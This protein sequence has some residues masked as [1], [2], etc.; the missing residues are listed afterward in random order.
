LDTLERPYPQ[1][2]EAERALLGGLLQRPEELVT[3]GTV[4]KAEDFYRPEHG[5]LLE[6]LHLM[7]GRGESIDLI[8]VSERIT[9]E[10]Q[11]ARYGGVA[12][13][14][15]LPDHAP[16]T[17]N[18]GHY[19]VVIK[20]KSMLRQLIRMSRALSTQA[21]GQPQDVNHLVTQAAQDF[22]S[23]GNT[24]SVRG[25]EQ[26][27][28]VVDREVKR[29]DDLESKGGATAGRTTGF[30]DLDERLSGLNPSDLVILAARPAMGKTA[31]ALNIA[32]NTALLE[33]V[34]VGLF[35]LEMPRGQL[36]TRMLCCYGLVDGGR[37]RNGKL[38]TD[39]WER[40][41]DAAEV[42]SKTP[43]FIDDTSGLSIGDVAARSRQLK[44]KNPDL[45]LIV[46][47]YLQLMRGEDPRSPREQQISSISRGLKAL[48]KELDCCVVA[49]S[50]LNRGVESRQ[51]KRP[52]VSDLR[53]SGAIEQDAD[54]ILFIYRDE[55][56]NPDSLDKGFAEVIVAKQRNGPTG[57]V[58]L[59]F[60]GEFARFDNYAHDDQLL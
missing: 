58:K 15:E 26:V 13:V 37:V 17:A 9:R 1:A 60:R 12:Y 23:L 32:Q 4:V 41:G 28:T 47:D 54:V 18:L 40:F 48:A 33:G 16:S 14:V 36:V 5:H 51:E 43:V 45:A 50:Q 29:I 10:A 24:S 21:Y 7:A 46:I 55:L 30:V 35:S 44:S 52:M 39:D 6:L 3:V 59:A 8:T 31:L 27:S 38:D 25:W 42:L 2:L 49:L 53:E 11:E 20:D 22:N 19:A 57:T 34:T 56:Y